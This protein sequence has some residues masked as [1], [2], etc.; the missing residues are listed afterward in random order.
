MNINSTV[1]MLKTK[2]KIEENIPIQKQSL[3]HLSESREMRHC[4]M[5][6][7]RACQL[8]MLSNRIRRDENVFQS[9]RQCLHRT[10][11]I[12]KAFQMCV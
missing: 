4:I 6:R 8:A 1:M 5:G 7:K 10:Q 9:H 3:W 2:K 11:S 12:P